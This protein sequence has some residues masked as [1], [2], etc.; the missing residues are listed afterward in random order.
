M[1]QVFLPP[2]SFVDTSTFKSVGYLT[3]SLPVANKSRD[4][5]NIYLGKTKM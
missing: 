5:Y 4:Y 2:S 3:F 1:E